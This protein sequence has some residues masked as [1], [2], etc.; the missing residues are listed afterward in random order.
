MIREVLIE[1]VTLVQDLE[2]EPQEQAMQLSE[3][4]AVGE[5]KQQHA[6]THRQGHVWHV[7]ERARRSWTLKE[8]R[9]E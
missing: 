8:G 4:G 7:Q 1:K 5:R 6:N 3:G 9:R 2:G